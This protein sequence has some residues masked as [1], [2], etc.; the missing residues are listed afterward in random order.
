M[1]WSNQYFFLPIFNIMIIGDI[2]F[3]KTN[4]S[5]WLS[6]SH[7]FIFYKILRVLPSFANTLKLIICLSIYSTS[8]YGQDILKIHDKWWQIQTIIDLLFIKYFH[9]LRNYIFDESTY[10]FLPF[11]MFSFR[12]FVK[13]PI[14]Q[15]KFGFGFVRFDRISFIW[16]H[17]KNRKRV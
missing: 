15:Q 5:E 10:P 3:G 16:T 2:Y 14:M 6:W 12:V 4:K 17:F 8:K 7:Q 13:I 11:M 9:N 1:Y